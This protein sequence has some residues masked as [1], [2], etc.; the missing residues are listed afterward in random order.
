M[1][2]AAERRY[3]EIRSARFKFLL[4]EG[5]FG[6]LV[7]GAGDGGTVEI[8]SGG[9]RARDAAP[10]VRFI[11]LAAE[12]YGRIWRMLEHGQPVILSVDSR[13]TF[14]EG[15]HNSFNIVGDIPGTDPALKDEIVLI[16]A[17]FDSWAA[18]TGATD[19]A[20]GCAVM[21]EAMRILAAL[22]LAPRRTIRLGLW[23]GE[24]QGLLGSRAYVREHY[25]SAASLT[26]EHERFSVHFNLDG[27]TGKIRGIGTQGNVAAKSIFDAWLEPFRAEGMMVAAIKSLG[28]SDHLTFDAAG[29]PAFAF[30]QDGIDYSSRTHHTN[31]DVFERVQPADMQFNAALLASFAWQAAQRDEKIPRR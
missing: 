6:I 16:G 1:D 14:S 19:N 28:A 27:G 8:T 23:T 24:E 2:T 12:H 10:G 5:A 4:D 20:A 31:Q 15:D 13:V 18:G 7:A 11:T 29:L 26:G 9:S 30:I 21:M 3:L 17:H 25:G 22:H